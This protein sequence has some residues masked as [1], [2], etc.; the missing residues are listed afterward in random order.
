MSFDINTN[1]SSLQAQDYLRVNSD[2]QAKTINR[3][4]S[5]LRIINSGDDAAGLAVANG[6]RS[7]QAVLTQGIRNANDGLSTLQTI[8]GGMK[9]I[10]QLLDRAR[11]LATQSA[12]DT[13][14]GDRSVLNSEFQN[15]LSEINRQ[16][17][18]I[19]M[20]SGGDFAK[21]MSVFIGGGRSDS[22][23]TTA[24]SNG[25]VT[26][27][28]SSSLLDTTHLGLSAN[29]VQ[30]VDVRS[31]AGNLAAAL[32]A[33][34]GTAKL[35]FT[36]A[37]FSTPVTVD[38]STNFDAAHITDENA[39]VNA[40]NSAIATA[41][42]SSS[43]FADAN[44]RASV[45]ASTG[46][47]TFTSSK[48][49]T[50]ADTGALVGDAGSILL[51]DAAV[52]D[53]ASSAVAAVSVNAGGVT[54]GTQTA[55]FSWTD[56][57]G[58][59][60][61]EAVALPTATNNTPTKIVNTINADNTLQNAGIFAVLKDATHIDFMKADGG[62]FQMSLKYDAT[63]ANGLNAAGGQDGTSTYV[64]VNAAPADGGLASA[65]AVD[66]GTS[67]NATNAVTALS[68]AV[69]TLGQIQG[70]VGK[71]ENQLGYAINL[72]QSQN[73]NLAAA[74]SRI[75][76]A[77]LASEAANLT[78]AQILIQAGTAALAQANTSSQAVLALL[79][80]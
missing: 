31:G 39:L 66:I 58:V 25:S 7:D 23:G 43:A 73:T 50:V 64:S 22:S 53:V 29:G 10:S 80:G 52:H 57:S 44:I 12:S 42:Q 8:D 21:S 69:A 40:I 47:L 49:F 75:R 28:L 56:S 19:G 63:G 71:A 41:G 14:T 30:G 70:N 11:T 34:A 27:D 3:V 36:G 37:G 59:A 20:T 15:V 33:A 6:Y 79:K 65:N 4:T 48:A 2:F 61:S 17:E 74:E 45:D 55:T 46:Q 62:A 54:L 32:G 60:H 77:D 72:A 38:F 67:G 5:G 1:I 13:F 76:D 26:V 24:I 78:K 51:G 68:N 9:N 35:D 18:S 16:A